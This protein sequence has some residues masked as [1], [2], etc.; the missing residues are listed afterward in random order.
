M[1]H[2]IETT[3]NHNPVE[4]RV[5]IDPIAG[6]TYD[7]LVKHVVDTA[8]FMTAWHVDNHRDDEAK[9]SFMDADGG[10]VQ[11]AIEERNPKTGHML[12]NVQEITAGFEEC[13]EAVFQMHQ[14]MFDDDIA[15][16]DLKFFV[17]E[18]SMFGTSLFVTVGA[19]AKLRDI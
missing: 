6:H 16:T 11:V 7:E 8:K 12:E 18:D 15:G 13:E 5:D 10:T 1:T 3:K 17:E 19:F 14:H 9:F 2:I 4:F